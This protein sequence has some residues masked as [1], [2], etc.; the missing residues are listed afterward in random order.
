MADELTS[1][2]DGLGIKV[3][4]GVM[5]TETFSRRLRAYLDRAVMQPPQPTTATS[6]ERLKESS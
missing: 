6:A 5:D 1:L 2:L 3:L 4:T